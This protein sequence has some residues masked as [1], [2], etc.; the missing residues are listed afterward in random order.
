MLFDR[1]YMSIFLT[2]NNIT[3]EA[4]EQDHNSLFIT[5]LTTRSMLIQTP[6]LQSTLSFPICIKL[7]QTPLRNILLPS[8]MAA[9]WPEV[10]E[11]FPT[12]STRSSHGSQQALHHHDK[13]HDNMVLLCK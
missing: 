9:L 7:S 5:N 13:M 11:K 2:M 4:Q 10:P 6:V 3:T 1:C 8:N 12:I